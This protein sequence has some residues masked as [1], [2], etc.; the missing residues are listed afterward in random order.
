LSD[1]NNALALKTFAFR[2]AST[3]VLVSVTHNLL[4]NTS[5]DSHSDNAAA[6]SDG[7]GGAQNQTHVNTYACSYDELSQQY[8]VALGTE[9]L[10]SFFVGVVMTFAQKRLLWLWC[11]K[12]HDG[13]N[14][15]NPEFSF[16]AE[17][18]DLIRKLQLVLVALPVTPLMPL[19]M[20]LVM[21]CEYLFDQYKLLRICK[22]V[23]H[24]QDKFHWTVG[25]ILLVNT[26]ASISVPSGTIFIARDWWQLDR[27]LCASN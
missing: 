21:L 26:L 25:A 13:D 7:S 6:G 1:L 2:L 16:V 18:D 5:K 23:Y 4:R 14:V 3:I 24:M 15:R 12:S 22:P 27:S 20:A 10:L 9:T 11:R 8:I 17:Y 19:G